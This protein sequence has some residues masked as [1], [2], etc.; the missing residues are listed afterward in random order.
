[1]IHLA[2]DPDLDQEKI[3]RAP[4]LDLD[5]ERIH[6]TQDPDL[7]QILDQGQGTMIQMFPVP[8]FVLTIRCQDVLMNINNIF[9]S[10][11]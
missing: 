7:D 2:P 4:G 1:M 10:M 6:L 8:E 11:D 5:Q 3:R 9:H